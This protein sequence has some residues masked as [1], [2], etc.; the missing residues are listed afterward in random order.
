MNPQIYLLEIEA[1]DKNMVF[2]L[3]SCFSHYI[4]ESN[5]ELGLDIW[6]PTLR[7]FHQQSTGVLMIS[8]A[9]RQPEL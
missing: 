3:I 9:D 7:T 2:S 4:M 1:L 5:E 6:V 8:G